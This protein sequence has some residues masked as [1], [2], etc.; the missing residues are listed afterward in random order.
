MLLAPSGQPPPT[1]PRFFYGYIIVAATFLTMVLTH[2]VR[3]SF[4][5]FFKPMSEE[6]DWTRAVT[7]G[8][9]S[10]S[11]IV[12]GLV[13]II[14]GHVNDRWGPRVTISVLGFLAGVSYLLMSQ[15]SAVWQLYLF[16]GVIGGAGNSTFTPLTSTITRWFRRRRS[17]MTGFGIAGIGIGSLA[18]PLLANALILSASW[19]TAYMILGGAVLVVVVLAAQ[20]LKKD[21][22]QVGQV[23]LG[24]EVLPAQAGQP[25]PRAFTLHEAIHTRQFWLFSGMMAC[26]A[27]S[28]FVLSV[29][30]APYATDLGMTPATAA[31]ILAMVG[32]GGVVGRIALGSI[33]DRIGNKWA[34]TLGFVFMTLSLLWLLATREVW[35]FY[36]FAFFFGLGYGNSA[37]QESPLCAALFGL[38]SHGVIFG[39]ASIGFTIGAALGPLVAG[40]IFDVSRSYIPAFAAA[41]GAGAL[42]FVLNALLPLKHVRA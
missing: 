26:L 1:R 32:V 21:P 17:L 22:A 14:V 19:Q 8:A 33:G 15:A 12:E 5:V 4:G 38:R 29:H 18:G 20:F 23:P 42:G 9:F 10:L 2:G 25:L 16:I 27:F 24:E 34:F 3:Y 30:L 37:T 7:S 13:S 11:W 40:Y 36:V 31:A 39:A 35:G 41:A 6:F 28:F